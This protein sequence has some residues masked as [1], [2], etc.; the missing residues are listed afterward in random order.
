MTKTIT[1]SHFKKNKKFESSPLYVRHFE[2]LLGEMFA[3]D[4]LL[5]I[6]NRYA[7]NSNGRLTLGES[8]R[9]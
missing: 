4:L 6:T 1:V 2:N 8:G 3:R 5:G 7:N 9:M